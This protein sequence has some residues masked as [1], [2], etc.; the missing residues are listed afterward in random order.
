M[1]PSPVDARIR[2]LSETLKFNGWCRTAW[3]ERPPFLR[4]HQIHEPLQASVDR[5][6]HYSKARLWWAERQQEPFI[7]QIIRIAEGAG[8]L[9]PKLRQVRYQISTETSSAQEVPF[10]AHID[11]DRYLKAI[12]YLDNVSSSDGPIYLAS[13]TPSHFEGKRNSFTRRSKEFGENLIGNSHCLPVLGEAG[14][15]VIFDTNT[16][17]HAGQIEPG[18]QRRILRLDF[19]CGWE[20]TSSK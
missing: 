19:D 9:R 14:T 13:R 2:E 15:V 1:N 11:R 7:R 17:H 18:G 20:R 10:A 16:P 5:V 12:L 3:A 4:D 8:Y 6:V